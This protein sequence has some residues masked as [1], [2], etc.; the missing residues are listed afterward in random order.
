LCVQEVLAFLE[1]IAEIGKNPSGTEV[2]IKSGE[3]LMQKRQKIAAIVIVLLAG[4]T[5]YGFWATRQPATTETTSDRQ[6][7]RPRVFLRPLKTAQQMAQLASTSEERSLAQEALRLADYDVD[8]AFDEAIREALLHPPPLSPEA[9]A[10]KARQEKAQ[11]ALEAAQER[12]KQLSEQFAKVPAGK[13]EAI[14]AALIQTEA[15]MDLA[16]DELDDAKHD[17]QQAGGDPVDQLRTMKAQH[18]AA[19]HNTQAAIPT[20]PGPAEQPGLI[21]WA[22]K[23][24]SLHQKQM[25]L[26]RAKAETESGIAWLTAKHNTLDAQ[27]EAQKANISE[28]P[29]RAK[30]AQPGSTVTPSSA[31]GK[32][33]GDSADLLRKTEQL[34]DDQKVVSAYDKR[35]EEKKE[36]AGVYAQWIDLVAGY[37]RTVVHGALVGFAVILVIALIA[38]F[39]GSWMDSL[40]KRLPMDRRQIQSLHT[41]TRVTL[42]ILALFLILLVVFG[43]PGQLGTFLGLAGAGLTVALKD[44]IIGFIGW[45]VLMGKNGMRMG[46][47]VEINGV[48]GEVVEIGP[49]HTVLLETGNWTDSGHPTGRRVTFTNSFAIEG[50]YFNFSTSGQWLWDEIH[51]VLPAGKDP[52]PLVDAIHKKVSEATRESAQQA[53][54]E[55]RKAT[56]SRELS[57]LSAAPAMSIK[58]VV[59][60]IEVAV[61]YITRASERY[62]LRTK[63][64]QTAVELLGVNAERVTS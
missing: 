2:K 21:H 1:R 34:A 20:A 40:V 8:L 30:T 17:L 52:S 11:K 19:G 58:P 13:Q 25:Q 50:H 63:L 29:K 57:G 56:N 55:W 9:M 39:F 28:L 51:I 47:W 43:P 59:G 12:G 32:G 24:R 7:G 49:F 54:A 26:W 16:Q 46:D 45:F 53:E 37:Q 38:L 36:L 14:E 6:A 35:I 23:W 48:T 44:F 3:F 31:A 62:M 61:R 27:I 18:E 4:L 5:L 64:N 22:M 42:Q 41:V 60:G 10:C 15:D 33:Q